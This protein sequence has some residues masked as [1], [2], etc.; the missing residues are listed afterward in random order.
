MLLRVV[1]SCQHEL[2]TWDQDP[3]ILTTTTL[4]ELPFVTI[5]ADLRRERRSGDAGFAD[6]L[7]AQPEYQAEAD[8]AAL[9]RL[10]SRGSG[11]PAAALAEVAQVT[12]M[13]GRPAGRP[14]VR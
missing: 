13:R 2:P 14:P 6:W 10:R 11:R 1:V 4:R 5:I 3:A 12:G 9:R 7:A 8:Q